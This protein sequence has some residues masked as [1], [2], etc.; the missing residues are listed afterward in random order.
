MALERIKRLLRRPNNGHPIHIISG[1]CLSEEHTES[2]NQPPDRTS[3]M[4]EDGVPL[5]RKIAD[6]I[7]NFVVAMKN[8]ADGPTFFQLRQI[9]EMQAA[10]QSL[11]IGESTAGSM[12]ETLQVTRT[13]EMSTRL[14]AGDSF[15]GVSTIADGICDI[16]MH[17]SGVAYVCA[18]PSE[19]SDTSMPYFENILGTIL[20]SDAQIWRSLSFVLKLADPIYS[21]TF[22]SIDFLDPNGNPVSNTEQP[23]KYNW[24]TGKRIFSHSETKV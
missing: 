11:Q 6:R 24:S 23:H 4:D 17:Y 10:Y 2:L 5:E 7:V 20:C 8:N 16:R 9:F 13:K 19:I 14:N 18:D 22:D 1:K 3:F 15:L 12:S 21:A